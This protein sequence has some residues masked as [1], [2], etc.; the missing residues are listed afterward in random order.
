MFL[1][2]FLL[3]CPV[4]GPMELN[5]GKFEEAASWFERAASWVTPG[6]L[7]RLNVGRPKAGPLCKYRGYNELSTFSLLIA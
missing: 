1:V 4:Q 2:L 7:T 5:T 6:G 3:F